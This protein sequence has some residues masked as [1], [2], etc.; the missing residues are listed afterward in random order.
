MGL[1]V[2]IDL[3]EN[4]WAQC[5]RGRRGEGGEEREEGGQLRGTQGPWRL[6][7]VSSS[8]FAQRNGMS[9]CLVR[10]STDKKQA[11]PR[12]ILPLICREHTLRQTEPG[13]QEAG[14]P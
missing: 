11:E 9:V 8:L 13:L 3:G 7:S 10:M 4:G 1:Q 6:T 2:L 14:K 5:E 12:P